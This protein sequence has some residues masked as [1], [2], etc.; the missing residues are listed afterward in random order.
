MIYDTIETIYTSTGVM[1]TSEDGFEYPQME[2]IDGYHVN[3][4][5]ATIEEQALIEPFIIQVNNPNRVFAG[6]D[7]MVCLKFTNREEWLALGFEK[8]DE[9]LV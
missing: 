4:L 6:R 1:L 2:A 7:D 8:T 9:E 3:V 5:D